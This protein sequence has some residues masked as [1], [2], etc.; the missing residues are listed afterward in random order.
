MPP[1]KPQRSARFVQLT[2]KKAKE[3]LGW[4]LAKEKEKDRIYKVDGEKVCFDNNN[5]NRPFSASLAARYAK[6]M[7]LGMWQD[8]GE[9]MTIDSAGSI[10]SCAHRCVGLVIAENMRLRYIAMGKTEELE[11]HGLNQDPKKELTIPILLVMGIDPTAADSTDTG[12]TR[13]LGDVLFRKT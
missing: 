13:T 8:N 6:T 11:K 4:R 10:I 9:S 7:L 3:I 2:A 12:K 1:K 5:T